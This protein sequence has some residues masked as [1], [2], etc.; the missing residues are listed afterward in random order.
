MKNQKQLKPENLNQEQIVSSTNSISRRRSLPNYSKYSLAR[1][2]QTP[3]FPL[4][5]P[6]TPYTPEQVNSLAFSPLLEEKDYESILEELSSKGQNSSSNFLERILSRKEHDLEEKE[7]EIQRLEAEKAQWLIEKQELEQQKTKQTIFLNEQSQELSKLKSELKET[8][9][10]FIQ[11]DQRNQVLSQSLQ[12]ECLKSQKLE[13]QLTNEID[14]NF[15]LKENQEQINANLLAKVNELANLKKLN[16]EERKEWENAILVQ[17]EKYEQ[18]KQERERKHSQE[19]ENLR[20]FQN[21]EIIKPI[22]KKLDLRH[23]KFHSFSLPN[24]N[25]SSYTFEDDLMIFHSPPLS[26]DLRSELN[27]TKYQEINGIISS[28]QKE[29]SNPLEETSKSK[30]RYSN[31]PLFTS[32]SPSPSPQPKE[33]N[34]TFEDV[35]NAVNNLKV[36]NTQAEENN[37]ELLNEIQ[38]LKEQ[39]DQ[40]ENAYKIVVEEHNKEIQGLRDY[41]Q[42]QFQELQEFDQKEVGWR[43]KQ[44]KLEEELDEIKY[45]LAESQKKVQDTKKEELETRWRLRE[46][47]KGLDQLNQDLAEISKALSEKEQNSQQLKGEAQEWQVISAELADELAQE[48]ITQKNELAELSQAVNKT[49]NKIQQAR[50]AFGEFKTQILNINNLIIKK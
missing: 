10:D 36:E 5:S 7:R 29:E 46:R 42:R 45:K 22:P 24:S 2:P 28:S 15:R 17:T 9:D 50:Q 21:Q 8:T 23:T 20:T 48:K 41:N 37:Q 35:L 25:R 26:A 1:S 19:I 47:E 38:Q 43:S 39:L 49:E 31:S 6:T 13:Q 14:E 18:E 40:S 33:N 27:R 3:H 11:I 4:H 12:Q 32:N 44:Q 34:N 16:Q 30:K